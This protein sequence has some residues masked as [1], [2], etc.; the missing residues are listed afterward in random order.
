MIDKPL[1]LVFLVAGL[2]FFALALWLRR[3]SSA[4]PGWKGP[5]SDHFDGRAFFNPGARTGST[6]S[7]LLKW[8]R[9][10]TPGVWPKRIPNK[11]QAQPPDQVGAREI[12][13]T[14]VNH[15]TFLIQVEGCNLLTDPVWSERVS[16]FSFV[17]PGRVRP[18]GLAWEQ[19]PRIDAVLIS[20]S[21]YDHLDL[22]TLKALNERFHPKFITGLGNR[23]LL[24]A[25]GIQEVEELDWWQKSR[26]SFAGLSIH[27][28]PA[29]HWSS[30]SAG[31]RNTTLWGGFFLSS[32]KLKCYFAG[33]SG[34]GPHFAA[35][36]QRL[37]APDLALLPIGAYEP[38]WFMASFHMGP[39]EA[40]RVHQELE[41]RQ[42]LGMHFDC[43]PLADEGEGDAERG[44]AIALEQ[45]GVEPAAF[46]A[47]QTGETLLVTVA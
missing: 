40:V 36:R 22:P 24:N 39:D 4:G 25:R 2:L 44:L 7:D 46:R 19:L 18:P 28:T 32:E 27:F 38:R 13:V 29:Q 47:P 31:E 26:S 41:A 30:R 42:S 45:A 8:R 3:A 1:T 33:D 11:A 35:I 10:R 5:L 20:H 21:H 6:F 9:S 12:A 14:L 23:A 15:C 17:G 34:Y 16:P 37:G 43:F